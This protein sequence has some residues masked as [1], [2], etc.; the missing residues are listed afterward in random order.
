VEDII[1]ERVEPYPDN[2][3]PY[4]SYEIQ[5]IKSISRHESPI[6]DPADDIAI[7]II[8]PPVLTPFPR[9]PTPPTPTISPRLVKSV[10]PPPE[11]MI[12]PPPEKMITP[13]P[14]RDIFLFPQ[15]SPFIVDFDKIRRGIFVYFQK[16]KCKLKSDFYRFIRSHRR[17]NYSST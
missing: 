4:K 12:T 5:E 16:K 8:T 15:E 13:P 3:S 11:K 7:P 14:I 10:T 2:M 6:P 17:T 1:K 9:L